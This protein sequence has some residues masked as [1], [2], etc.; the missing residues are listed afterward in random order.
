MNDGDFL[1]QPPVNLD[2]ERSLLGAILMNN[3]AYERVSEFLAPGHFADAV[4][5]RIYHL[6]G[7]LIDQGK[8]VNI[9]TLKTFIES[10]DDVKKA[11][12]AKY[13]ASL[14]AGA[15]TIINAAEYGRIIYE[16]YLRREMIALGEDAVNDAFD[17]KPDETAEDLIEKMEAAIFALHS[18]GSTQGELR[19]FDAVADETVSI[20]ERAYKHDGALIGVTTGLREVDKKM[21]GL[22]PAD[23]IILAG[24]PSMGK[25]AAAVTI[26]FNAAHYFQTTDRPEHKNKSVAFFSLEM[27]DDQLMTRIFAY[28]AGLD[29]FA[30]RSGKLNEFEFARLIEAREKVRALPLRIDDTASATIGQIRARC[31]RLARSKDGLGL[32]VIDYLQL[33]NVLGKDR[34]DNRTQEISTITRGLKALAKELDVPVI[35]LSQLSRG[36]E[37]REDKRPQLSDLRE[38]G[39][40]EADADAVLFVY[41]DQY[42]LERAEPKQSPAETHEKYAL[43]KGV[44]EK[45]LDEAWG[46]GEIIIAKQRQG[47]L[48]AVTLSFEAKQAWWMDIT[49][50]VPEDNRLL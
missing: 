40:I 4:N 46:K 10:D 38:S 11:G 49:N 39:S 42:Y 8:A 17:V 3:R 43:R 31:R 13:I 14:A 33:I 36:V 37:Q 5:G 25:T 18:T 23:L 26:A 35:A 22:Q 41:R 9:V 44:W 6:C 21:G 48:G 19:T 1:R 28:K 27:S 45:Q 16:M 2:A 29:S 30:I 7:S 15:V 34:S 20:A 47:P 50:D 24:R 32:V 12:G